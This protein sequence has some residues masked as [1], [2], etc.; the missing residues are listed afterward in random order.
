ML[1]GLIVLILILLVKKYFKDDIVRSDLLIGVAVLCST[2]LLSL[3]VGIILS[4]WYNNTEDGKGVFYRW[5]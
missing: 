4:L 5:E 3:I 1:G 2:N